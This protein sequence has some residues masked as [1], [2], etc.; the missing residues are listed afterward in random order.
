MTSKLKVTVD[1][2]SQQFD[3]GT[4]VSQIVEALFP[5]R[6]KAGPQAFVVCEINGTLKDL[7]TEITDGDVIRL[8]SIDSPEGLSV[9]RH[10]TAH[11]IGRA[12]V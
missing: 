10:S 7:W 8:I 12:H 9:L 6:V 4:K 5:D 2:Q 11:E 3:A 1:G